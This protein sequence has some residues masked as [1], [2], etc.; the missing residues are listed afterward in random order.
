MTTSHDT[1]EHES[2]M[3]LRDAPKSM[4]VGLIVG[5]VGLVV[6]MSFTSSQ[7]VNG[8][9]TQCTSINIAAFLAAAVC[10][11]CGIRT[12]SGKLRRPGR[13]PMHAG[14]VLGAGGVILLL[15]IVHVLRGIGILSGAC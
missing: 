3:N 13:Y 14:I 1:T 10:L 12:I 4:W 15:A 7:S 8:V 9:V 5:L 6:N 2:T 11:L